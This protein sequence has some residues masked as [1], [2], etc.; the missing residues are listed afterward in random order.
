MP[1]APLVFGLALAGTLAWL[2]GPTG[3]VALDQ[4][5]AGRQPTFTYAEASGCEGLLVYAWNEERTEVLTVRVDRRAVPLRSGTTTFRL[6]KEPGRAHVQ[7]EVT[8]QERTNMQFC[9]Q[10]PTT[11]SDRP[12]VWVAESGTLK[13]MMSPRRGVPFASVSVS[14]DDL[15]VRGPDRAEARSRRDITFTAAVALTGTEPP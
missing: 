8:D 12:M 5:S 7:V 6:E 3:L 9:A 15:V 4:R 14:L 1:R 13:I 2:I 10:Q 11:T